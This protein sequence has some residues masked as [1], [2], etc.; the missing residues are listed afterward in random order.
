MR[1]R[2]IAL[3]LAA[4][5]TLVLA[6]V[7]LAASLERT[8]GEYQQLADRAISKAFGSPGDSTTHACSNPETTVTLTGGAGK[9]WRVY[10]AGDAWIRLGNTAAAAAPS[11][12][13]KAG[14]PERWIWTSQSSG[15]APAVHCFAAAPTTCIYTPLTDVR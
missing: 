3:G 13:V 4:G 10:C 9:M 15:T 6:G 2:K 8:A 7:A 1:N 14:L 12:P 5:L 11:T